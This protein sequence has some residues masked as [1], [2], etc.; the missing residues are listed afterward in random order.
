M[1]SK[2][3]IFIACLFYFI[4]SSFKPLIAIVPNLDIIDSITAVTLPSANYDIALSTY[5]NGSLQIKAVLGLH[6]NIYL[7]ASFDAKNLIGNSTIQVN[8]PGVIVKFKLTDGWESFPLLIAFGYDSFYSGKN[9]KILGSLSLLDSIIYGPYIA[10]SRPIFLFNLE[11]HLH[12]GA[13]MPVQPNYIPKDTAL[14]FSFDFPIGFFIP[15]FEINHIYLSDNRWKEILF[16]IGIKL[17]IVENFSFEF[18]FLIDLQGKTSRVL[19]LE[20]INSF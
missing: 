4:G 8:I 15:M 17:N 14:Y 7:G 6:N 3:I 2:L 11:Q 10:I 1:S 18:N 16:N 5:A 19:V 20:Y 9:Q 12:L 13:R